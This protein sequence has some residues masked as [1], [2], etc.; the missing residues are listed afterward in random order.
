MRNGIR[1]TAHLT[2]RS[3]TVQEAMAGSA[4][5]SVADPRRWLVLVVVSAAS[6]LGVLDFF[7]VNVS[8]PAIKENLRANFA[9]IQLMIAGYGLT[10][11]VC[12]I[13]GGRLGDILGR[14]RMFLAGMAGFTLAS[15]LCGLA[16]TPAVLIAARILQGITGAIMFPQVLSI[17]QVSFP[18]HERA[19]A[20][21]I[22]GMIVGTGSFSGNVLGGLLVQGNLFGLGW[23]PIFLVNLPLGVVALVAAAYLV[24]ES[25]SPKAVRLDLGG[26]ALVSIGLFLLVYPLVEG[27]EAGWPLEMFVCLAASLPA[28]ATF[29]RYEKWISGRGGSPLVELGLFRN[30]VFVAGLITTMVYYGGL[31]AFFLTVTV[32]LQEG[33]GLSPLEAGLTFAPFAVG[34]LIASSL[35]VKLTPRLGRRVIQLGAFLMASGLV[36]IITLAS[37]DGTAVPGLGLVPAL[38]V[39]GVGQGFVMPTLLSTVLS[40]IPTHDAGSAS[41]VLS[42]VQ[43]VALAMGVAVIG[44][45]FF[46]I[47]GSPAQPDEFGRAIAVA[48]IFNLALLAATIGLVFRL[49][50][51]LAHRIETHAGEI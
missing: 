36:V 8:I 6:F 39:Y 22:F 25:R 47:L 33:L 14:K 48:L 24:H 15:A 5:E 42:T 12:L 11:A 31:S 34:F 23:R 50:R 38:M 4:D 19:A 17:I 44:S 41:G 40:G 20:F 51:R 35:A 2:S 10:Y 37:V 1:Q 30:R 28:L 21:G 43:Q 45:V 3:G 26:V 13:T 29:A 46:A 32:Y 18:V 16:P 9:E 49:P 7:I 27:R